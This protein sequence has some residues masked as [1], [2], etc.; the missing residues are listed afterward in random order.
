LSTPLKELASSEIREF[1]H[2]PVSVFKPDDTA[3]KALGD[4]KDSGR[5]EAAVASQG[6]VGLIT[7]RDLL[8]VDQ[9]AQTKLDK[10]WKAT[11]SVSPST[12]IIEVVERLVR[13]NT[14]AL[15]VVEGEQV[16]GIISQVDIIEAMCDVQ[17]LAELQAKEL[18]RSPVYSLDIDE[19]IAFARRMMLDR[20]ISHVPIVEYGRLVGEVT[21]E[22]IVH[23]FIADAS[24][25]TTGERV[26][27]K[28]SRFPGQVIGI[29]DTHPLSVRP[30]ASAQEVAC[31]LRDLGKGACYVT[32]P[33]E[34]PLGIITPR[35]LITI[36]LRLRAEPELPVYIMGLSD[37]DFFEKA[38]A[39]D[40]VR[41][42]VR[43]GMRF[44]P[45]ITEVSVKIKS[46][47][48]QGNRTRYEL[49]A[50]AMSADDQI[51]AE[52][53]GWDLL[54]AFDELLDTLGKA[55]RRSKPETQGTA[56]RRRGRQVRRGQ[57]F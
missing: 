7:L 22:T 11:G 53:Q 26:G 4:L 13:N 41:R 32:D 6:P 21:A 47:Q 15:P 40:K 42:T 14:R 24:K 5:Y 30:E 33:Q 37:E 31:A 56:R 9:P 29:M 49:T 50:R 35:E 1:V 43:R 23:T 20:G 38:V 2:S 18:V 10:V 55:L 52:A 8:G 44:R 28:T 25:A 45:D 19:G 57:S 51:N 54:K 48:I 39:E 12:S 16:T 34:R 17:E 36:F 46:S 3:S 27:Q